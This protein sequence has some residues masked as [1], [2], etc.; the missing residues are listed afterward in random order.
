MVPY[1]FTDGA[2]DP[3]TR[4][5]EVGGILCDEVGSKV[6][7]YGQSVPGSLMEELFQN[8]WANL[9]SGLQSEVLPVLLAFRAWGRLLVSTQIA[10]HIHTDAARCAL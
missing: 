5:V 7:A 9:I 8:W 1:L 6:S 10:A 2:C 3:Q 4:A